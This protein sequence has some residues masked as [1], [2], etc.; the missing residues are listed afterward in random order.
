MSSAALAYFAQHHGERAKQLAADHAPQTQCSPTQALLGEPGVTTST[1]TSNESTPRKDDDSVGTS[2]FSAMQLGPNSGTPDAA[3]TDDDQLNT[4]RALSKL[5]KHKRRRR[6]G[7]LSDGNG[8]KVVSQ[9]PLSP[10]GRLAIMPAPES[11][12]LSVD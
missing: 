5:S 1:G 10:D 6:R 11:D 3:L 12:P 9:R 7:R 4:H 2:R 8:G